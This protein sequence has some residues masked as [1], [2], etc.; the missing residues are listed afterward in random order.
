MYELKD[1][2]F[3]IF[4]TQS[5]V[6]GGVAIALAVIGFFFFRNKRRKNHS[7]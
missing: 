5:M 2:Y 1:S 3:V 4:D 7:Q 6:I